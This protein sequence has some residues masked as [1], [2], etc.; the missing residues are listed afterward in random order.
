M[1]TTSYAGSLIGLDL[2]VQQA[3]GISCHI[4]HLNNF[5]RFSSKKCVRTQTPYYVRLSVCL[6]VANKNLQMYQTA[7][8]QLSH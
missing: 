6:I 2:S 4:S 1:K 5:T 8:T 7:N 3:A